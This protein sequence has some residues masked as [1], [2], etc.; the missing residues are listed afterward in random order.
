M[1]GFG[2]EILVTTTEV[3][4]AERLERWGFASESKFR[5]VAKR[6]KAVFDGTLADPWRRSPVMDR[7][8]DP[9]PI[10]QKIT[11]LRLIK[12]GRGN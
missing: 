12:M 2:P 1:T 8:F 4:M 6:M 7:D 10:S 11:D 9:S 3:F 5:V